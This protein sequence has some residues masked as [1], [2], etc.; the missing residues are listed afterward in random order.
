MA[1][2]SPVKIWLRKMDLKKYSALLSEQGYTDE[3][4]IF[5]LNEGDLDNVSIMD[6]SDRNTI[7][8]AG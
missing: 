8:N 2:E 4:D 1:S 3:H 5:M 7:L 6:P